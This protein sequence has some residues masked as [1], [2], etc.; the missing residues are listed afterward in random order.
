MRALS[1]KT[2]WAN[3]LLLFSVILYILISFIIFP[4]LGVGGEETYYPA[5]IIIVQLLVFLIPALIF[6]YKFFG[7]VRERIALKWPGVK[8]ALISAGLA[9]TGYGGMA[10]LNIIWIMIFPF[11][12]Y[13]ASN[14]EM[15]LETPVA[16]LI[17]I[18]TVAL[19]PAICEEIFF[20][21]VLLQEYRTYMTRKGAIALSA[22]IFA[23]M[24]LQPAVMPSLFVM[25][26]LMAWLV[27]KTGSIVCAMI[28]HFAS[29][30]SAIILSWHMQSGSLQLMNITSGFNAIMTV[31]II[32]A[33]LIVL[34]ICFGLLMAAVSKMSRPQRMEEQPIAGDM[35]ES[36]LFIDEESAMPVGAVYKRKAMRPP[37]SAAI[38]WVVCAI[39]IVLNLS[40]IVMAVLRGGA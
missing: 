7:G 2:A 3:W 10:L 19:C 40:V 33:V 9:I 35:E 32:T 1:R 37:G 38:Y 8:K 29:N 24:H 27:I 34:L 21:G 22:L 31:I 16:W 17:Y 15:G 30:L 12:Q 13:T 39:F 14:F 5:M 23:L 20:R 11:L 4:A 28:Y 25:G 26:M 18:L 6:L 36:I